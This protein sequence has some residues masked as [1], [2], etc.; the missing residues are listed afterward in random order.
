MWIMYLSRQTPEAPAT[1]VLTQNEVEALYAVTFRKKL[2]K[3]STITIQQVILWIAKLGGFLARKSDGNPGIK[4][5]WR[6]WMRLTDIAQTWIV[7]RDIE[8]PPRLMGND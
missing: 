6:G 2:D 5:M 3:D 4:T 8:P 1:E 7:A